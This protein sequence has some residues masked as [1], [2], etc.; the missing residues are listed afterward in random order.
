MEDIL[1]EAQKVK[2]EVAFKDE[3]LVDGM[4]KVILNT[5]YSQ[6]VL[7]KGVKHNSFK[8]RAFAL[9]ADNVD[10]A[11][12][13]SNIKAWFEGVNALEA[14]FHELGKIKSKKDEPILSNF[15]EAV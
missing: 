8:N 4:K 15:N 3:E 11:Q 6:G 1:T 13:G 9:I 10:N 7:K 14:G 5:I 2:I 12:L